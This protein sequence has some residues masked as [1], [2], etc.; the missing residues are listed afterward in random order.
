MIA[1][2]RASHFLSSSSPSSYIGF[3]MCLKLYLPNFFVETDD[4]LFSTKLH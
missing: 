2:E 3:E 4:K 1:S